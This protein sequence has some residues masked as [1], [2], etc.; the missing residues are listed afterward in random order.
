MRTTFG[1]TVAILALTTLLAPPSVRPA[2]AELSARLTTNRLG[3]IFAP[4]E[5]IRFELDASGGRWSWVVRDW[6][7]AGQQ[8]GDVQVVGGRA[9]IEAPSSTPGYFELEVRPA[10]CTSCAPAQAAY[11]VMP[12]PGGLSRTFGAMTHVAHGWDTGFVPLVARAGIGTIRDEQYWAAVEKQPGRFVF[13]PAWTGYMADLARTGIEPLL[14]MTFANKLYDNGTTPTSPAAR[15]AYGRYGVAL[16]ERY[17]GQVKALEVWNEI[18][19]NWC[20]GA[21]P[22]DRAKTYVGLL[23]AAWTALKATAPGITVVGGATAGVPVPFW[24][25]LADRGVFEHLDVAS[26]HIYRRDPEGSGDEIADLRAIMRAH[27]VDRPIWV[28]ETGNGGKSPEQRRAA[29]AWLVKQMTILRSAQVARIYWY[30]MRDYQGFDGLGLL[31]APD[32]PLGR[33]APNPSYVAYATLIR[34][35]DGAD[36]VRREALPDL[37]SRVYLFDKGGKEV[38]VAWSSGG[39]ATLTIATDRALTMVDPMGRSQSLVPR[40]GQ[41]MVTLDSTPFFLLGPVRALLGRRS[42]IL[43]ADSRSDFS[44]SAEGQSWRYGYAVVQPGGRYDPIKDF[45]PLMPQEN[46]WGAYWG[47]PRWRYLAV[48]ADKMHPAVAGKDQVLAVRRWI[49]PENGTIGISG[50]LAI[51]PSRGDGTQAMILVDGQPIASWSL[52]PGTS[53]PYATTASVKAGSSVDLVVTPGPGLDTGW[54]ATTFTATIVR[55]TVAAAK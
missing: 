27:G 45:H 44:M 24:R 55:P 10:A 48:T 18:N 4:D 40:Q 49:A 21:C 11:A 25:E 42:E 39:T 29:A 46:A 14:E 47:D 1:A 52:H 36:P 9:L 23:D 16:A 43:L 2:R 15:A 3:N 22:R 20:D 53:E 17:P 35:L 28:T 30:L 54:D 12:R 50:E 32:S 38:R 37:R 31:R 34:L 33:Y 6:Q 26:V 5:P 51:A 8:V 7:G 19:G 13:P 41:V